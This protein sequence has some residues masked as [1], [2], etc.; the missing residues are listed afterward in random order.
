MKT[1]TR[2]ADH[3]AHLRAALV[4]LTPA[5]AIAADALAT[6]S[7][8][9]AAAELAG[10]TR[11]TV[12]RWANHHP[13]FRAALDSYRHALAAEQADTA[14]RLRGK[15]LAVVERRLDDDA[16]L[17]TALAVLRALPAPVLV[18]LADATEHF[19]AELQRIMVNVPGQQAPRDTNGRI[20]RDPDR[21]LVNMLM[22]DTAAEDYEYRHR[23]AVELL[24]DSVGVN[25][26]TTGQG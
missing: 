20:L 2:P 26:D 22:Y 21:D 16:D 12:T 9:E 11:E 17:P 19:S 15:A 23:T 13:A 7:T 25:D 10:V 5:Q 14:R 1:T 24:A 3:L 6:G 8:H 18:P 4:S